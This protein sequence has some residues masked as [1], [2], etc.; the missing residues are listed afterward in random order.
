M[1]EQMDPAVWDTSVPGRAKCDPPA[2]NIRLRP[3]EN[4]SGSNYIP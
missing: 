1:R 3:W 4:T 2:N